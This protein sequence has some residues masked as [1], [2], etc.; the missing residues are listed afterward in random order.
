MATAA[1]S[2]TLIESLN[3]VKSAKLYRFVLPIKQPL[4]LKSGTLDQREGLILILTDDEGNVGA[5][6]I[7]PLPGFSAEHL[8]TVIIEASILVNKLGDPAQKS[9]I[10]QRFESPARYHPSVTYYGLET[11]LTS[12]LAAKRKVQVG[13][14]LFGASHEKI[15]INGLINGSLSD[16]VPEAQRA[17]R[18]GFKTLKIKVGRI[19]HELEARGILEIRDQV[20]P[21]VKLRLDANRSWDLK[22]ALEFGR[23]VEPCQ[24]E[25]I[26]EPLKQPIQLPRFFDECG[27][28]FAFDESL[29][30]EVDPRASFDSYTGLIAL[31]MKPMLIASTS[32]LMVL[33]NQARGNGLFSVFSS[34]Y[35]S[36][37][38]LTYLANLA[39][40]LGNEHVAMGLD[41]GSIFS[42]NTIMD[43]L[44]IRDGWMYPALTA[45]TILDLQHCKLIMESDQ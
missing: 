43:P 10:K 31:V 32:R 45:S 37:V 35:E 36:D 17:I 5:G 42:G 2:P 23:M 9:A 13:D 33:V 34:S 28:H 20:G 11:A 16:W 29:Y 4:L 40:A 26:E 25:Y 30:H 1:L 7:S 15:P 39:S 27:L 19:N 12:L 6:E 18:S 38:G 14:I 3:Y 24:I 8:E 21:D 41:T 22:T 44:T